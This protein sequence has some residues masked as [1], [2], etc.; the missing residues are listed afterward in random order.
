MTQRVVKV[1]KAWARQT[2]KV[3]FPVTIIKPNGERF[4]VAPT[5]TKVAKRKQASKRKPTS[6]PT[7]SVSAQ[8]TKA[9]ELAERQRAFAESQRALELEMRGAYN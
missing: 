7:P 4:I 9:I 2:P 6:K 8:D 1:R 3:A 5:H